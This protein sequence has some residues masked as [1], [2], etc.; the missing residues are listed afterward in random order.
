MTYFYVIKNKGMKNLIFLI[1]VAI[2]ISSCNF[3]N[4]YPPS[5]YVI[6]KTS[7]VNEE[8]RKNVKTT[9]KISVINT[10]YFDINLTKSSDTT[11]Q[12]LFIAKKDKAGISSQTNR[13]NVSVIVSDE[14]GKPIYFKNSTEFLIYMSGHGYAIIEQNTNAYCTTTYRFKNMKNTLMVT[15]DFVPISFPK[16]GV[17]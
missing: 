3:L 13:Q 2:C 17:N 11:T 16:L 6:T 15:P 1:I 4:T 10:D 12:N 5:V 9:C 14:K 8:D 7:F